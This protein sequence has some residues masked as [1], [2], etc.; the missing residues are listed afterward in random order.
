M[1]R[2]ILASIGIG[3]AAAA[4]LVAGTAAPGLGPAAPVLGSSRML[5]PGPAAADE[6]PAF[7]DCEQLRQWYVRR[8]LRRVGPWGFGYGGPIGIYD[9]RTAVDDAV[10]LTGAKSPEAVGSSDTG[11]NVQEAG[12]DEPD[13]A[14]TDGRVVVRVDGDQL[15]VTDVSGAAVRELSRLSLPGRRLLNAELLLVGDTVV[16]LGDEEL[17]YGGPFPRSTPTIDTVGRIMPS[18][19]GNARTHLV[20]VD[21]ADP[22]VPQLVSNQRVDGGL[23]SARLYPDG[24]VRAVV[25]TG[26]PPLDFVQPNRDRTRRQATM[27]NR[28][29]VRRTSVDQW[30]PGLSTPGQDR[31]PLLDCTQVRHPS[32]PA[33]FGTITVLGFRADTPTDLSTTATAI[34][35]AGDLVYSSADRLYVGT[36]G[37]LGAGMRTQV[38]AFALSGPATRYVASGDLPGTVK[39]RWSFSEYDGH[40]RVAVGLGRSWNPRENA[41]V[42][43]EEQGDRLREVGRVAGLGKG[44]RIESVRWF[45]DL[46]V[47]VTFRQTDPLYTLDLADPE[48]PRLLGALKIRG[49]STYLHPTGDGRILGLGQDATASGATLG[50]QAA[51]FDLRDLHAVRRTAT[52]AFGRDTELAVGWDPRTFTFVPATGVA[53]VPAQSWNTGRSRLVALRVDG[54]SLGEARSW[55]LHRWSS[56]AVRTL[57]LDGGRVALVDRGVRVLDLT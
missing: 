26:L 2:R 53:L 35:A 32:R 31:R 36:T 54:G 20:T 44:E 16:V 15:V 11:T 13:L 55:A 52:A 57:P 8:A 24:T 27:E 45:D 7:D 43:L 50:A 19:Q 10:G 49:F 6:L 23:V 25:S 30:L 17:F 33:G 22:G 34:T 21:I 28:A 18:W 37:G 42:V 48:R 4:T 40:L 46:A 1:T 3:A 41:V 12:V 9:R 14:K 56:G 39:D 38:H 47:V 29:I 51:L 5:A